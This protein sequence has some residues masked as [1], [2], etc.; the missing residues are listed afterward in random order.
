MIGNGSPGKMP[1]FSSI[2]NVTME[3]AK[4]PTIDIIVGR[5]FWKLKKITPINIE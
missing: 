3:P 1:F 4:M 2:K 5:I